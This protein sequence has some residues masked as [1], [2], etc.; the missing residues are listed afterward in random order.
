MKKSHV[1]YFFVI[2]WIVIISGVVGS[3]HSWHF[4]DFSPNQEE[5]NISTIVHDTNNLGVIHFLTPKCSCSKEIFNRL[6]ERGPI[7]KDKAFES[8]VIVDDNALNFQD[9][10]TQRGFLAQAFTSEELVAR[11]SSS[12]KGVPL[13]IIYDQD[14]TIQY[15]GG[16]SENLIN[17]LVK[18]NIMKFIDKIARGKSVKPFPVKGCSVSEEY[19][20]ILDPLGLKYRKDI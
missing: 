15:I 13:L 18:I 3:I 12:M 7:S 11:V 19:K 8:V 2:L 16:Y 17:P 6:I 1:Q 20:K 5:M 9:K 10:L 4:A 14:K